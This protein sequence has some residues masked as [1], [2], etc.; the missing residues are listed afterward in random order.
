MTTVGVPR[1]FMRDMTTTT[2][3]RIRLALAAVLVLASG[4]CGDDGGDGGDTDTGADDTTT[5]SAA[6]ATEA[7]GSVAVTAVDYGYEGVPATVK[8]GT[9][10]TLANSS[11]KEVH[12]IIAVRIPDEEK[13]AAADLVKDPAVGKLFAGGPAAVIVAFPTSNRPGA[14]E[15]DGSLKEPGRYLLVCNVPT[16]ADPAAYQKAASESKGGP[17]SVPGGPPHLTKGMFAELTVES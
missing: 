2:A 12:E 4:A 17:V 16:G 5:T 11:T 7:T 13:R 6:T 15:G 14:V 8:A 1:A 3:S 10:L 9:A